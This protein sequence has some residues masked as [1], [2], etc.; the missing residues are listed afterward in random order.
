MLLIIPQVVFNSNEVEY[1]L[2]AG[3]ININ[4]LSSM[5]ESLFIPSLCRRVMVLSSSNFPYINECNMI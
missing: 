1:S 2:S 5:L 3:S 4:L